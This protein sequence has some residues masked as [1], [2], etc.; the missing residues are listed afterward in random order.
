[1]RGKV[2]WGRTEVGAPIVA[3]LT[4]LMTKV[5]QQTIDFVMGLQV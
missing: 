3:V 2:A 1:M 5:S 4:M